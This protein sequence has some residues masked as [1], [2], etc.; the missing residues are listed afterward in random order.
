MDE[1]RRAVETAE[2]VDVHA[3]NLVALDSS[4]PFISCFSEASG[5]ALSDVT[6]TLNFK[7]E[8]SISC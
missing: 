5:K 4:L 8:C 3:H 7:M 1:L 2:L 6:S